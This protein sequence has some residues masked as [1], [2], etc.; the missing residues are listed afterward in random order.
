M[1]MVHDTATA[2]NIAKPALPSH[3][4]N[5]MMVSTVMDVTIGF[6][7]LALAGK[8]MAILPIDT[9][10]PKCI[11]TSKYHWVH[12]HKKTPSHGSASDAGKTKSLKNNGWNTFCPRRL[13]STYVRV[14]IQEPPDEDESMTEEPEQKNESN[15][16]VDNDE[17][18]GSTT[19][20]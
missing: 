6:T 5:C 14:D 9:W 2:I 13:L 11:Q 4:A 10:N 3:P 20:V 15:P 18:V 12:C 7:L 8:S 19:T 16:V 17:L 1:R